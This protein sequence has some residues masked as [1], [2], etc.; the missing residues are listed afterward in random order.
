MQ[1]PRLA[2]FGAA[3]ILAAGCGS[4]KTHTTGEASKT[5]LQIVNDAEAAA[6]SATAVHVSGAGTSGGTPLALDLYLVAGK[7]G[8]G[9][10]IVNGLSFDI[11]RVG[12]TAYFRGDAA[13]WRHFGGSA[14]VALMQGR[15]LSEPVTHGALATFAPLTDIAKLF[16]A[17]L[18]AHGKL[19]RGGTKTIGGIPAIGIVDNSRGGGTLYVAASGPAYPLEVDAPAGKHGRISFE[20]WNRPVT[21]TKPAHAID[22]S[23][24][25]GFNG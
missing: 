9:H 19:T 2:L 11:V 24:L 16:H 7:G 22:V 12:T 25:K 21:V 1:A 5:P 15:W 6:K 10:L 23:K 13:F 20:D 18:R 8:R 4:T 17:I 3:V 14:L